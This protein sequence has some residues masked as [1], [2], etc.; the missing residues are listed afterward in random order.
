MSNEKYTVDYFI[1]KF[2]RIPEDRWCTGKLK[3]EN[4][5]HCAL[6]WCGVTS[7]ANLNKESKAL[8]ALFSERWLSVAGVNDGWDSRFNL[9]TPKERILAALDYI[10]SREKKDE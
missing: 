3:T 4:E 7:M 2:K 5:S 1:E 9:E 8:V 10:K 6:G